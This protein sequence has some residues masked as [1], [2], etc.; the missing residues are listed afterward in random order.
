MISYPPDSSV[1]IDLTTKDSS[2]CLLTHKRSTW[3]IIYDSVYFGKQVLGGCPAIVQLFSSKSF[4][5]LPTII[6]LP[7]QGE[8]TWHGFL[9]R[10][11]VDLEL[12]DVDSQ[13]LRCTWAREKRSS[14]GARMV[15]RWND[16]ASLP[17]RIRKFVASCAIWYDYSRWETTGW[18]YWFSDMWDRSKPWHTSSSRG[19]YSIKLGH[20][21]VG[22][23]QHKLPA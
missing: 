7:A 20:L 18:R 19:Q 3:L 22:L 14:T 10:Y 15:P 21:R 12:V 8:G 4:L 17:P 6:A 1:E 23:W 13:I 11:I 16:N 2:N 9:S 5:S